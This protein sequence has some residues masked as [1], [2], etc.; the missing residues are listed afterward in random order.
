[1]LHP[2]NRTLLKV[3]LYCTQTKIL[4][5]NSLGCLVCATLV[6]RP[7]QVKT[8]CIT[9]RVVPQIAT[10]ATQKQ[11]GLFFEQNQIQAAIKFELAKS[12][13]VCL[14]YVDSCALNQHVAIHS[15]LL[16]ILDSP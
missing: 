2:S 9:Y 8:L 16:M 10:S 15:R 7:Q 13:T 12:N 6:I 5:P 14:S 3:G 11:S 4:I 1:M